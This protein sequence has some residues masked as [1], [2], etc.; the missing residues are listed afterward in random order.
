M[1]EL[2]AAG[3][4]DGSM[5][6]AFLPAPGQPLAM[7]IVPIPA[8]AADEVL[9]RVRVATV[10]ALRTAESALRTCRA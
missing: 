5:R 7:R 8:P 3:A 9:V 10:C 1:Q 2:Q 6:Q 4:G